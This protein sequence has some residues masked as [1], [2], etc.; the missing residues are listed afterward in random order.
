MK[1]NDYEQL[2]NGLFRFCAELKEHSSPLLRRLGR[3]ATILA[4][5][6]TDLEQVASG[7]MPED[8]A[9]DAILAFL[10][11][12]TEG[13]NAAG[14]ERIEE[15]LVGSMQFSPDSVESEE[16]YEES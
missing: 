13:I 9:K 14:L 1:P 5:L 12:P 4:F 8:G 15:K 16:T 6:L 3:K 11:T 7:K 2:Q 10:M